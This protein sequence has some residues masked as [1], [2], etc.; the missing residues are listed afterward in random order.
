MKLYHWLLIVGLVLSGILLTATLTRPGNSDYASKQRLIALR[1]VAHL[2]LLRSGDRDTPVPPVEQIS[3]SHYKISFADVIAI[4][5][6]SLVSY[7]SLSFENLDNADSYLVEVRSCRTNKL[8]YGFAIAPI[9]ANS[10]ISCLGRILPESCYE[11]H[12]TF[13]A[14]DTEANNP[15][16]IL[17][18]SGT[19][20]ALLTGGILLGRKKKPTRYAEEVIKIGRISFMPQSRQLHCNEEYI[21]LTSR[22]SEILAIFT[23]EP[24]EIISRKKLEKEVWKNK[25]VIVG[26]SL[27]V[28]I[29]KLRK[30]LSIDPEVSLI[31]VHGVGYKLTTESDKS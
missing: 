15:L 24:G 18:L 22:E 27:D 6:D 3:G 13:R 11:M 19:F 25:G 2:T 20:L 26:R 9:P 8:V 30:K 29:S 21:P 14:S 7:A 1:K 5:P 4:D 23:S 17:G 31:N 16:I 12:V 28:F 10:T